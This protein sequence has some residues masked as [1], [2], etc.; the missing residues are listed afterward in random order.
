MAKVILGTTM[1]LD[2]FMTDRNG[3]IG[4]LYPD[5][6]ALG[7]TEFLKES[8]RNTGAAIM[9][10]RTFDMAQGDL[11]DYEYQVPIFVLTH[12]VPEEVTK[13]QNER[14]RVV[15]VTDGVE[16]AIEQAKAAAGDKD[17]TF[18]GGA[19][20]AQQLLRAGLVDEVEIGIMPLLFGTGL[21]FFEF[22]EG[23]EIKLEKTRVMETGER[24]DMWFRV[25]K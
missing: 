16:S 6:E 20:V 17:V 13:G 14:L 18:V 23:E 19:N 22:L 15:F 24:T 9:G 12:R 7:K 5:M 21:R 4:R 11:T 8:I 1:S 25:V 10:R 2:G 3:D